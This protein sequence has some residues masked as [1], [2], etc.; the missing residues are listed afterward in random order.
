MGQDDS[1]PKTWQTW[2]PLM[3]S[4]RE[5]LIA[6]TPLPVPRFSRWRHRWSRVAA[7]VWMLRRRWIDVAFAL[8]VIALLATALVLVIATWPL[9]MDESPFVGV[10]TA[11]ATAT[12]FSSAIVSA[13]AIPLNAASGIAAGYT[14]EF[15]NR[16]A[17]WMAGLYL[18]GQSGMLFL[19]A[20][21]G[22][23]EQAATASGFL[24]AASFGIVWMTVRSLMRSADLHEV[25]QRQAAFLRRSALDGVRQLRRRT[26]RLLPRKGRTPELVFRLS[27]DG[28]VQY[29]AGLLRHLRE[30]VRAMSGRDRVAEA[31]AFWDGMRLAFLDFSKEVDGAVGGAA[32]P[33]EVL[34]SAI[35][36]L[37]TP[38]ISRSRDEIATNAIASLEALA[39]QPYDHY[40]YS[41]VRAGLLSRLSR[42][43]RSTWN[44]D[45]STVPATSVSTIGKAHNHFVSYGDYADAD[46]ALRSL[47]EIAQQSLA[48]NRKHITITACDA[49]V[50]SL[51][52]IGHAT[53]PAVRRHMLEQWRE[54]LV[55]TARLRL[56]ELDETFQR[57]TEVVLPG[58][59]LMGRRGL[60]ETMWVAAP[61]P[62]AAVDVVK[63]VTEWL[64]EVMP[65]LGRLD[66]EGFR[67]P[68]TEGL[69]VL[70][71]T[72]LVAAASQED[73]DVRAALAA[74]I[75]G[76]A[77]Q[78]LST[79][80]DPRLGIDDDV[81][82]MLW[83]TLLVA[84]YL[85]NDA[86]LLRSSAKAVLD[87]LDLQEIGE[88]YDAYS[89]NLL[90]G[91][92]IASG[93]SE[94]EVDETVRAAQPSDRFGGG[95]SFHI[96][97]F[98]RA[99]SLNRN[100]TAHPPALADA[101]NAWAA[102]A[103]PSFVRRPDAEN[104]TEPEPGTDAGERS[105]G[106][107]P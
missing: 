83:S 88:I 75:A 107:D 82:E 33:T 96:D 99:P 67:H 71:C 45:H 73:D 89:R 93:C 106:T 76:A 79:A 44:N 9:T 37:V 28:E 46:R 86:A 95:W 30:G 17:P 102:E 31:L 29:F 60:Q 94:A 22:P 85:A 6:Q 100:Q 32:G 84:G 72:G 12:A 91:L 11:A 4:V 43:T 39:S 104:D 101:V 97:G 64:A 87:H 55:E 18:V 62:E 53:D 24:A 15:L 58:I 3:A 19:I 74:E 56:L 61:T 25:A 36:D 63:T 77:V 34:F 20:V 92:L 52:S 16:K 98:G 68:V 81:G 48:T 5:S 69:S 35:D 80:S 65:M 10:V 21:G 8:G 90:S 51:P 49:L 7:S 59:A 50:A 42:W 54:V 2:D 78:W 70:C 103:F 57:P 66:L 14:G 26:A 27:I 47:L 1:Q 13:M 40:E 41:G 38:D 105:P 23:D